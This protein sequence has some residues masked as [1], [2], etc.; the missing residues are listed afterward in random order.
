MVELDTMVIDY[1]TLSLVDKK[2][3]DDLVNVFNN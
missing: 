2:K 1:E 3:I